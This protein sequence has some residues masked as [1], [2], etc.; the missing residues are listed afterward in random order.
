LSAGA[1]LLLAA[2]GYGVHL[3]RFS[4][5]HVSTDDAFVAAHISPVSARIS[6]TIIE[7][8]V[9]DNQ[10]VHAGDVLVRLD[11]RDREV[12][13]AQTRAAVAAGRGDL[14]NARVNVPLA[15]LSTASLVQQATSALAA[16][17]QGI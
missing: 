6:G 7:V 4:T 10:D 8:L 16:A 12:A 15:D 13:L 1:I 5:H 14:E 11:P 17:E 2:A 9:Q 3:W